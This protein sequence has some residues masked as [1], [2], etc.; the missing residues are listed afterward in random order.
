MAVAFEQSLGN[1]ATASYGIV[2]V[3]ISLPAFV[4]DLIQCRL[5]EPRQMTSAVLS[6]LLNNEHCGTLSK[7]PL[8]CKW[9]RFRFL[10]EGMQT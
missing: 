3:G 10:F 5:S 6:T 8:V 4:L 9:Y 1:G 7:G 2:T